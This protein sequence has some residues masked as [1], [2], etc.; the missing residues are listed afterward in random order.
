MQRNPS[1][2]AITW[3]M[4][5]P[6]WPGCAAASPC[7]ST[8]CRSCPSACCG[9][10]CLLWPPVPAGSGSCCVGLRGL[11]MVFRSTLHNVAVRNDLEHDQNEPSDC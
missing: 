1:G 4:S 2:F 8:R 11:L 10:H 6:I 9:R 3:P 5:A 7:W